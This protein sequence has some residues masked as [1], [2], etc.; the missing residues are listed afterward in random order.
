[1]EKLMKCAICGNALNDKGEGCVCENVLIRGCKVFVTLYGK[2][3]S[4]DMD[5]KII[6]EIKK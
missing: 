4:Y 6:T 1:M 5:T 2:R 3:I